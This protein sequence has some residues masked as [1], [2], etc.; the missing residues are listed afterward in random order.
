MR[1]AHSWPRLLTPGGRGIAYGGDYYPEQ[2]PEET[3]DE[4]IRLMNKAHVNVVALGIFAWDRI[5]P[6]EDT[7]DFSW[8]DRIIGKLGEAGIAVDLATA[9]ASAPMWLYEAHPEILPQDRFGHTVNPGS[10]QSWSPCSPVFREYALTM[11]RT[12]ARRYGGNP[13]VTSW[14]AGN[15]YGW[16]NRFD[17]SDAALEAFR[18][19]CRRKYGT[20]E[21]LNDAWCTDFWSQ[22]V[23]SFDEVLLPRHMGADAMVNPA[24]W[25][26]F[27]RF[28]N[29]ALLDFYRAERDAVAEICPDKPVTTNFMVSTDQCA[30]DYAQWAGEVDFLSNDHYFHEGPLHLDEL[31][32][33]DSLMGSM[34]LGE[35]WYLMEHSTSNVQWKPVNARK[36][37][38]ELGRDALAHV[39]MGADAI[40]FFQWRQSRGEAEAFHSAMLPHAGEDTKLF[41][42]VCATGATLASL[43]GVQG[44]RRRPARAAI[45]FDA[46]SQWATRIPTLP[47][48][49]LDHWH[50]VRD[51][52]RAFAD[53]GMDADV[54]PLAYD[55][56]GYDVVILPGV[57]ML[58][59]EAVD[60][61]DAFAR[62][63]G[64]V[65]ADYAT[66]LVDRSFHVGLGGYPGAGGGKLRAMLGVSGEEFN[67]VGG[68]PGEPDIIELSDG[69]E[70]HLWQTVLTRTAPD[71][72]VL[73]TYEGPAAASWELDGMAALTVRAHGDGRAYYVGCDLREEDLA[74]LV[75]REFAG[76]LPVHDPRVALAVREAAD[77]DYEFRFNRT[78]DDVE[79]D[80][81]GEAVALRRCEPAAPDDPSAG[82]ARRR[83][84]LRRNGALVTRRE[85]KRDR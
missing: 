40:N 7:W 20:V 5:Q 24:Q 75:A 56:S 60:R 81:E 17:Y 79:V 14:H 83:F 38:G 76:Q 69:A 78:G 49:H 77:G 36:R 39:A 15:E 12:L 45:L 10:R 47:T 4:D 23:N 1:R 13:T 21:A 19:W 54:V 41:A 62:A 74:R 65:V 67:I 72:R 84:I 82:P 59:D 73:A 29:D 34:A 28:G 51:W 85:V 26:D 33:S 71:A 68:I 53:T 11:C 55:W 3:W 44:G 43:G 63:G 70:S 61:L 16:N 31:R 42:Q 37:H 57:L 2:W 32:C 50:A 35:P 48:R 22:R 46:N 80:V 64:T 9:T 58:T 66:G 25:L 6:T 52:Y 30:M 8:L 18:D 27:E